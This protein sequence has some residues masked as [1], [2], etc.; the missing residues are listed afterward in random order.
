MSVSSPF[1]KNIPL[2]P[3]GKSP[4]LIRP[5]HPTRGRIAIVTNAGW[6]AVDAE[7]AT[8]NVA[9]ADGEVVWF[10]RPKAGVKLRRF[11][12]AQRWWQ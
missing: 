6:D 11:V 5:S 8:T 3:S 4:L 1:A 9:D 10:R 2:V 7:V 12:P